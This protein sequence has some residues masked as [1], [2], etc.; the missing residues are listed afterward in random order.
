VAVYAVTSTRAIV[1]S[2]F[3]SD[4]LGPS[5]V[6]Q[7]VAGLMVGCLL[8]VNAGGLYR[9]LAARVRRSRQGAHIAVPASPAAAAADD[10]DDE[11]V[12]HPARSLALMVLTVA[13]LAALPRFGYLV[14]TPVALMA[15][16]LFM[17]VRQWRTIVIFPAVFTLCLYGVFSNVFGIRLP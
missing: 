12:D 16:L 1:V 10:S 17:G 15:T 5:F 7:V 2:R 14:T 8:L 13:Y 3:L 11:R 4:P 9:L 6:P